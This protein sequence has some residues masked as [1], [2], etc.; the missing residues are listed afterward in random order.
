MNLYTTVGYGK[1][2]SIW[3]AAVTKIA[4]KSYLSSTLFG[5]SA[6]KEEKKLKGWSL[7]DKKLKGRIFFRLVLWVLLNIY[8]IWN[9]LAPV[10]KAWERA[11][12]SI[13]PEF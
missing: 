1:S 4:R 3:N 13:D 9:F 7:V 10:K 2:F 11:F 8:F 12:T 6:T 5:E